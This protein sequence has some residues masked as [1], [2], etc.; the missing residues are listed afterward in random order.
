MHLY[1]RG[2]SLLLVLAA[3]HSPIVG[4]VTA[5]TVGTVPGSGCISPGPVCPGQYSWSANVNASLPAGQVRI[6]INDPVWNGQ[7]TCWVAL[8]AVG[9]AVLPSPLTLTGSVGGCPEAAQCGWVVQ[10]DVVYTTGRFVLTAPNS[11]QLVGLSIYHQQYAVSICPWNYP[12]AI[13]M[14]MRISLR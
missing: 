2:V 7:G 12:D 3:G 11:P 6:V 9:L 13:S 10:P 5:F 8:G 1:Q 14:A 4:Q